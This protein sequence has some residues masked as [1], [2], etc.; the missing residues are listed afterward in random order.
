MNLAD[1]TCGEMI[2]PC[3]S[4]RDATSVIQELTQVMHR[5]NRVPESLPFFHAALNRE[6][7]ASS[8]MHTGMAFPHARVAGVTR[9]AF[10]FGRC[11][12][13]LCWASH[14]ADRVGLVFLLAVPETD[15]TDY[16]ALL[17]G[18][19]RL[20]R[21]NGLVDRLH[22]CASPGE[23]LEVFR[24]IPVRKAMPALSEG[25]VPTTN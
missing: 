21:Q 6:F 1:F 25:S 13:P 22:R 11:E 4:G 12:P 20:A 8:N 24:Q 18:L 9:V 17:S 7:L 2:V 3:L 14:S 15:S 5:A 10:A 23:I 19:S 16:L